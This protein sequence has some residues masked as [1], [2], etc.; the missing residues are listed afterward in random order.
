MSDKTRA[1]IAAR[2]ARNR[3]ATGVAIR[4]PKEAPKK[5]KAPK[6][7]EPVVEE[8]VEEEPSGA[9]G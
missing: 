1:A 4:A 2:L 9:E 5:T 3:A 6:V 7:E 8:V